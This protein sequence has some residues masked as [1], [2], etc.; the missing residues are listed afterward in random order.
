MSNFYCLPGRAGGTPVWISNVYL[1]RPWRPYALVVYLNT[2]MGKQI[3]PAGWREWHPGETDSL[4]T[5]FYAEFHS[6][7]PGADPGGRE[8]FSHQLTEKQAKQ[9]A[10]ENWLRGSDGWNPTAVQ[11]Q[12]P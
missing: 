10:P 6:S 5:A 9:F 7:G 11:K 8:P 2:W 3:M 12:Q 4:E 1:G